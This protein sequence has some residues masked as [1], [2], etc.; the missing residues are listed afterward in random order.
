[1]PTSVDLPAP[2]GPSSATAS[3]ARSVRSTPALPPPSARWRPYTFVTP[4]ATTASNVTGVV[5]FDDSA[6]R[7]AFIDRIRMRECSRADLVEVAIDLRQLRFDGFA[8]V[9]VRARLLQRDQLV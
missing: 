2:F 7:M 6:S 1:M 9:G 3:P 8:L 5:V 4:F